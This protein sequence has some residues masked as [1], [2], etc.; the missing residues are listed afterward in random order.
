ML[1]FISIKAGCKVGQILTIANDG[2]DECLSNGPGTSL[3]CSADGV[4]EDEHAA[5]DARHHDETS[6]TEH[7]Y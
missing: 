1:V 4:A 2:S 7:A 5:E 3:L 6:T